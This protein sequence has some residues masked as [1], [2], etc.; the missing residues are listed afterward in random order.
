VRTRLARHVVVDTVDLDELIE[1]YAKIYAEPKV[2][3]GG[4]LHAVGTQREVGSLRIGFGHYHAATDWQFPNAECFLYLLP[5]AGAGTVVTRG[6][7][8]EVGVGRSITMSPAAGFRA[9]YDAAFAALTLKPGNAALVSAL[10]SMTGA[11]VD[12]PLI[13]EPQTERRAGSALEAYLRAL[14]ATLE[15]ADATPLPAWWTAQTAHLISVLLLTEQRHNYS[16]LFERRPPEPSRE[17]VRYA[18]EFIAANLDRGF[19]A[20]DL[21]RTSGVSVLSLYRAFRKIHGCSPLEFAARL[22]AGR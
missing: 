2:R 20:E 14:V 1:A 22:R 12:T 6:R 4:A 19:T 21:A 10:E 13:F 5:I 17:E 9:R 8:C 16:R 11:A 15:R 7:E 18:E 3:I